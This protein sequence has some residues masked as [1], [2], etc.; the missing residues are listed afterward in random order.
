ML[1]TV[2]IPTRN[3]RSRVTR[4]V[5]QIVPQLRSG[6]ELIVSDDASTDDTAA[7]LAEIPGV[8]VRRHDSGLGMVENWNYCL[9]AGSN[10]W[11]CLVHDDDQLMPSALES[12]RRIALPGQ[13][14]L[15]AHAEW[16]GGGVASLIRRLRGRRPDGA[17]GPTR[18]GVSFTFREPGPQAALE[19]EF[20]P[21]GVTLHRSIVRQLGGFNPLF[22]YS[23][24]MEYFPRIC[25]RFP[26]YVIRSPR[27]LKYVRH[28][29]QYSMD[30]WT[31]QDFPFELERVQ[32]ASIAHAQMGQ[33]QADAV[34]ERRLARD[35]SHM[36]LTLCRQGNTQ[37][38]RRIA[39]AMGA[40]QGLLPRER[41]AAGLGARLGWCPPGLV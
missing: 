36:L 18:G 13:A 40:R 22:K 25:A 11:V 34:L 4:L 3:R 32:R 6:D 38:V 29:Q 8:Q 17:A 15:V 35:M 14:A 27:F 26:S 28:D 24:D 19:A 9:H 16:E 41:I 37:Q 30:T 20:C 7:A 12:L 33:E 10:E 39:R 23:A 21:S 31:Q 5:R 2:T 1:I